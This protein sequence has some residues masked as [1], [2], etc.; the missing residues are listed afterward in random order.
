MLSLLQ[1]ARSLGRKQADGAMQMPAL[2][3]RVIANHVG[4]SRE[5]VSSQMN[6][7]RR[8]GLIRYSRKQVEVFCDPMQELL[9]NSGIVQR[10]AQGLTFAAG[11]DTANF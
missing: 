6:S 8:H 2:T 5:I 11:R 10:K 9:R 7:L 3:H 4:T 1:L